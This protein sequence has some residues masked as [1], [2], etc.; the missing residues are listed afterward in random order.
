MSTQNYIY[1]LLRN[2]NST[3]SKFGEV[4]N[5]GSELKREMNIQLRTSDIK[6]EK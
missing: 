2:K 4:N 1:N 5:Y 3:A 6:Y